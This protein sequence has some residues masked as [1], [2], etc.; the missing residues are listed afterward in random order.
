MN[1]LAD[2]IFF[3]VHVL[4]AFVGDGGGPV[5]AR[6]VIVVNFYSV[7]GVIKM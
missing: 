2:V 1:G 6:F 3:E 4:G 5:D 7:V